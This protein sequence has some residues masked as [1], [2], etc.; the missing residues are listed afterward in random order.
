MPNRIAGDYDYETHGADYSNRR[1]T[2]PR[3]ARYVHTALGPARIVLNVGAGA[4]SYEPTDRAVTAVEPSAS[5][6]ALRGQS[7]LLGS[8]R[9]ITALP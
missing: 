6:R 2:D 8:M 7:E 4:D 3:I 5:M 1:R 9:L